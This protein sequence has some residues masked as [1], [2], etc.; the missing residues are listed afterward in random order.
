M[1]KPGNE[2][3]SVELT[4]PLEAGEYDAKVVWTGVTSDTHEMANPMTFM[5]HIIVE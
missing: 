4:K 5:F 2:I 3:R 1:I